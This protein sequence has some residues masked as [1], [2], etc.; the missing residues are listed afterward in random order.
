MKK[1]SIILLLLVLVASACT[2]QKQEK[3]EGI[4]PYPIVSDSLDNGLKLVTVP[5]DSPGLVSFYIIVRVGS[6]NEV[7]PGKTGFAHFFEHMMFRG[8]DQYP[9]EKY[10]LELKKIGASANANTWLDRTVYHMTGNSKMMDKMFEIEADRFQHLNYSEAD[11]KVEAGAVK[12]EY[13][14]N[15]ANQFRQINE[16]MSD[17]AFNVHTYEHTTMGFYEDIVDMPNQYDYSKLFYDRFYRPE[18]TTI[19]V[20]GDA[21]PE[22]VKELT[23][24]YFGQWPRGHYKSDIKAEP[25]QKGPRYAHI[26]NPN[27]TPTLSLNYKT[28]AFDPESKDVASLDLISTMSF[29]ERSDLY[30]KLVIEEQKAYNLMGFMYYTV[31]PYLF[32]IMALVINEDD[33][34]YVKDAITAELDK[35]KEEPVDAELLEQ[36]KSRTKYQLLME[37]DDPANIAEVLSY[38]IWVSNDPQSINKYYHTIMSITPEDIMNAARKY[39]VPE[40]LTVVT[41]SSKEEGGVK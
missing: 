3:E 4:F 12:G 38:F 34:Q 33:L 23:A 29:S 16:L 14:K 26:Q 9:P 19:L 8:T 13:T 32:Q 27:F 21:D 41:V 40:G 1:T 20:V 15:F 6:R 7:E 35:L 31:D 17:S 2:S 37:L 36:T 39:F 24:K 28:P 18:Y 30:K 5:Y 22:K 25:E 11:F 10:S